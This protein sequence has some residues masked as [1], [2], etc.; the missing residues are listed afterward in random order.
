MFDC[1]AFLWPLPPPTTRSMSASHLPSLCPRKEAVF[2]S[3]T[4]GCGMS[5]L[6]RVKK[7]LD[8]LHSEFVNTQWSLTR[9]NFFRNPKPI[10]AAAKGNN[11]LL[12]S[13]WQ[14]KL[15]SKPCA[16]P[17]PK[18][19]VWQQLGPNG[20]FNIKLKDKLGDSSLQVSRTLKLSPLTIAA[21]SSQSY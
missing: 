11:L 15:K 10:F 4:N 18:N 9:Q 12:N 6:L 5:I 1:Q 17:S 21:N 3:E 13:L 19:P 8:L 2:F 20:I 14:C 16:V 7:V